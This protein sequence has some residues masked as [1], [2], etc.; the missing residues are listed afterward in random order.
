MRYLVDTNVLSEATTRDP[1]P[2]VIQWLRAHE[3]ELAV[4]P[5]VLGEIRFGIRLLPPGRGRDLLELWFDEVVRRIDCVPMDADTGL[6]WAELLVAL[7]RQGRAMPV[8]DSLIAATALVHGLVV[9][10]RNRKDFERAGVEIV[11]P[12]T[13]RAT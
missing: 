9:A 4:N 8:R 11:N 7:R 1:S 2:G 3:Q 12:F 6:R 5:I 10:T 13:W